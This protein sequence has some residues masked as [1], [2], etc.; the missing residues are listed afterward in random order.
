[1]TEFLE[2]F[3]RSNRDLDGDAGW[4]VIGQPGLGSPPVAGAIEILDTYATNKVASHESFAVQG[5][6]LPETFD[7]EVVARV[8]CIEQDAGAF[9]GVGL[10]KGAVA[11]NPS[12]GFGAYLYY[13][14]NG[15]RSL[16]LYA[17]RDGGWFALVPANIHLFG[18]KTVTLL[19]DPAGSDLRVIQQI[20][21]RARRTDEGTLIRAYLNNGDMASPDLEYL[22]HRDSFGTSFG[23][24]GFWFGAHSN[25]RKLIVASIE[26]QDIRFDLAAYTPVGTPTL[27]ELK[28]GALARY[29]GSAENDDLD[30][31]LLTEYANDA[32]NEI[33]NEVGDIAYFLNPVET[34]TLVLDDDGFTA[35]DE[36]VE[37]VISIRNPDTEREVKWEGVN[38]TKDGRV[39]VKIDPAPVPSGQSYRVTFQLRPDGMD[40]DSD[41]SIIP[42]KHRE[43]AM[44]AIAMRI[45]GFDTNAEHLQ[46]LEKRYERLLVLLKRDC[47]RWQRMRRKLRFHSPRMRTVRARYESELIDQWGY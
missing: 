2:K 16:G 41:H 46:W 14:P 15:Q 21:V 7:Q 37:R 20:R 40:K 38:P 19:T 35:F 44:I 12:W 27:K 10:E 5:A 42:R 22:F 47:N 25:A 1:M 26:A 31:G 23:E 33:V 30:P 36:R 17:N 32:I 29:S 3:D 13:E 34:M 8:A 28:D 4:T 11:S 43:L 24:W 18:T 6:T 39:R 45:G 9:I